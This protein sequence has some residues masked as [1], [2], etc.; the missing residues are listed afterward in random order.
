MVYVINLVTSSSPN[1]SSRKILSSSPILQKEEKSF[2]YFN[3]KFSSS[4]CSIK[5]NRTPLCNTGKS[6]L[7]QSFTDIDNEAYEKFKRE[8]RKNREQESETESVEIIKSPVNTSNFFSYLKSPVGL[9]RRR[10]SESFQI[11]PT[12]TKEKFDT[13][14]IIPTKNSNSIRTTTNRA[15]RGFK[16]KAEAIN[17]VRIYM[18]N[19][20]AE[21]YEVE[22]RRR[23]TERQMTETVAF[24]IASTLIP[25]EMA[26]FRW[27]F[28]NTTDFLEP[29]LFV[30]DS[31][32][33]WD[34]F[35]A[36]KRFND[37]LLAYNETN[38]FLYFINW[39]KATQKHTSALNKQFK[40]ALNTSSETIR[41]VPANELENEFFL[42]AAQLRLQVN[43]STAASSPQ[44]LVDLMD[45]VIEMTRV[46]ALKGYL[47]ESRSQDETNFDQLN[48]TL[49]RDVKVKSGKDAR[50]CWIKTLCQIPRVTSHL[51]EVV[52]TRYPSFCALME[53]YSCC[54]SAR[55][56]EELLAE[57]R[58][59]DGSGGNRRLGPIIS[60]RIYNHF[61]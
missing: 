7:S 32:S 56:G 16:N 33:L 29:R 21:A 41:L 54:S 19:S 45:F 20:M 22:L 36:T 57:L 11:T 35:I 14:S 52:V 34:E 2:D 49:A 38:V 9:K 26:S 44:S 61:Q 50:D 55:E 10:T 43:F 60:A 59:E 46:V 25:A 48:L 1:S 3:P 12:K 23:F 15:L 51:A 37:L 5:S 40:Q 27:K 6:T 42:A 4:P 8:W 31:E 30:L 24:D 47:K 58:L 39:K 17:S 18:S 28:A 53:A 13:D